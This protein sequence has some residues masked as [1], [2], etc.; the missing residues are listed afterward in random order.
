MQR[1]FFLVFLIVVNLGCSQDE[2]V[3]RECKLPS[4]IW[5]EDKCFA[6]E[7]GLRFYLKEYENNAKESFFFMFTC[8]PLI[9]SEGKDIA[10]GK[11]VWANFN[12]SGIITIPGQYILGLSRFNLTVEMHCD[13]TISKILG[14]FHL[15][16]KTTD[17]HVW[18]LVKFSTS[19]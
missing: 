13:Q 4:T 2:T 10:D 3:I 1:I 5:V 18:E 11:S 17:C 7:E 16:S 12:E 19:N 15:N 8:Y 14:E 9:N 6:F